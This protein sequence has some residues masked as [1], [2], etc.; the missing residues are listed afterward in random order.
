MRPERTENIPDDLELRVVVERLLGRLPGRYCD[1][2]DDVAVV[3]AGGFPH[4]TTDGLDDVH[5]AV[6]RIQEDDRVQAGHVDAFGEAAGVGEDAADVLPRRVRFQPV[7]LLGALENVHA[8]VDVIRFETER[9]LITVVIDVDPAACDAVRADP[10]DAVVPVQVPADD[11]GFLDG[12][13]E[14]D[15]SAK[16]LVRVRGGGVNTVHTT[17]GEAVVDPDDAGRVGNVQFP[18][19][20]ECLLERRPDGVLINGEDQD[21][22]VGEEVPF[23]SFPEPE[24][25]EHRPEHSFVVHRVQHRRVLVRLAASGLGIDLRR[26]GHVEPRLRLNRLVRMHPQERGLLRTLPAEP[27][28]PVRFVTDHQVERCQPLGLRLRDDVDRL[29]GGEEHG[30]PIGR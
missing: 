18:I 27:G 2:E 12:T 3:L 10:I 11:L 16:R 19:G 21:P 4:D 7:E 30:Q 20:G 28:R 8:A 14:R 1:G 15:R 17:F 22:V 9:L 29:V 25:V 13:G 5:R 26:R 24:P 23:D 6:A